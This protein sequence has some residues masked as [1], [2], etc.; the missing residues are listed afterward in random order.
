LN[1]KSFS[2]FRGLQ[3]VNEDLFTPARKGFQVKR[4]IRSQLADRK[5]R[6]ERRLDKQDL[7]GMERPMFT[8][9]NIRDEI[10]DRSR[11]ISSGGI[12]AIHDVARSLGLIQAIGRR[13]HLL[14][15]QPHYPT[16]VGTLKLCTA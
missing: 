7:R 10:A 8:A 6:I 11:G 3:S 12:G 4:M 13:L 2:V 15:I 14:K 16:W 1:S 5:R 9:A